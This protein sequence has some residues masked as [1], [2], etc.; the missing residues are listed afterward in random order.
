MRIVSKFRAARG[1]PG[2]VRPA[3]HDGLAHCYHVTGDLG[4]ARDHWR[5]ALA[6]YADLADPRADQVRLQLSQA[7]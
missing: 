2:V 4:R 5:R 3:S 1:W 7:E 6:I